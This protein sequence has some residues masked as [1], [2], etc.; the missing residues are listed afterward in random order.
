MHVGGGLVLGNELNCLCTWFRFDQDVAGVRFGAQNLQEQRQECSVAVSAPIETKDELVETGLQPLQPSV[1]TIA[2]AAVLRTAKLPRSLALQD[3][4]VAS[5]RRPGTRP[6]ATAW[7]GAGG[8]RGLTMA[9]DALEAVRLG[10]QLPSAVVAAGVV[11]VEPALEGDEAGGD[12][13]YGT[14][15]HQECRTNIPSSDIP[16]TMPCVAGTMYIRN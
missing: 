7:F 11:V 13:D 15:A 3:G 8:D 16:N 6:R 2:V 9:T 12:F 10:L 1:L 14:V 5:R 4:T